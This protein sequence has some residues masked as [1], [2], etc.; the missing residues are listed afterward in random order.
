MSR[1]I[2][3]H[4]EQNIFERLKHLNWGLMLLIL[5]VSCV[6]FA[7]LYSA[8]G[9]SFSPWASKQMMRFGVAAI[10]MIIIALIDLK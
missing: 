1:S 5:A 10:G 7:A 3:L 9:G 6:G 8:A 2:T 4:S